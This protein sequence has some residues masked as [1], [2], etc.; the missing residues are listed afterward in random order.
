MLLSATAY[1]PNLLLCEKRTARIQ[2]CT[3]GL[4]FTVQFEKKKKDSL[5]N[6][7]ATFEIR[8]YVLIGCSVPLLFIALCAVL[9]TRDK[10][11]IKVHKFTTRFYTWPPLDCPSSM[12]LFCVACLACCS[13]GI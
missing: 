2:S 9:Y 5:Y 3:A 6:M 13:L 7:C 4:L 11:Y 10:K 12:K 8:Y 1:Q